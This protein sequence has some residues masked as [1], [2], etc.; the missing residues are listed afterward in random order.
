M[1]WIEDPPRADYDLDQFRK[2]VGDPALQ[3]FA[4]GQNDAERSKQI[5]P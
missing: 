3:R 2:R 4:L 5:A 1:N